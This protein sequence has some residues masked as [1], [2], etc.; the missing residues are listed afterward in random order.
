VQLRDFTES[1]D[2]HNAHDV[3]NK[4]EITVSREICSFGFFRLCKQAR[5]DEYKIISIPE[6]STS[7]NISFGEN[8]VWKCSVT[9]ETMTI[10]QTSSKGTPQCRRQ[11]GD[12]ERA[13]V[14]VC[15][16]GKGGG[17]ATQILHL[18]LSRGLLAWNSI[19]QTWF[20]PSNIINMFN[21]SISLQLS[22][23]WEDLG[24]ATL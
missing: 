18:A 2:C 16:Y 20:A 4:I 10:L 7:P 6:I 19:F 1:N 3:A 15:V 24:V 23:F 5:I 13:R 14:C 12:L 21:R 22:V 8:E 17:E 9:A 11:N